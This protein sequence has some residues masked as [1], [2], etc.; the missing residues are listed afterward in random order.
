M[1]NYVKID[2][3]LGDLTSY[4]LNEF[5]EPVT[6]SLAMPIDY[7][8]DVINTVYMDIFNSPELN[9]LDKKAYHSF[10]GVDDP[11]IEVDTLVGDLTI[12][13]EDSTDYPSTGTVNLRSLEFWNF[14][15]NVANVLGSTEALVLAYTAGTTLKLGYDFPTDAEMSLISTPI[16]TEMR[17][18]YYSEPNVFFSPSRPPYNNFTIYDGKL[19]S[20]ISEA[21]NYSFE[22]EQSLVLMIDTTSKPTLIPSTFRASLLG[23]GAIARIGVRDDMRT[24]WDYHENRYNTV[25][26]QFIAR[27]NKVLRQTSGASRPSIYD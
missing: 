5:N 20:G 15:T 7:I 25:L 26:K 11:V 13:L 3:T 1:T 24:G 27:K 2:M 19:Y 6:G 21:T 18:L 23:S 14:E 9:D 12:T 8:E 17:E 4:I 22:Y 10:V 16:K